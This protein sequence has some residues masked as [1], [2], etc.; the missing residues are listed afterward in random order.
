MNM[1]MK[2]IWICVYADAF[3]LHVP[4]QKILGHI[5][6][7]IA[8]NTAFLIHPQLLPRPLPQNLSWPLPQ[9]LP[10]PVDL[11]QSINSAMQ[12]TNKSSKND[13]SWKASRLI[14]VDFGVQLGGSRVVV[15]TRFWSYFWP[16]EPPKGPQEQPKRHQDTLQDRC[17][18][19][20]WII[21]LDLFMIFRWFFID[22][23]LMSV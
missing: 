20:F 5:C 16:Q 7:W 8:V 11:V 15:Q 13:C 21:F 14:F 17:L 12:W 1:Y 6:N 10:L 3:M 4:K 19:P 18:E 23:G 9:H 22:L 2:Y